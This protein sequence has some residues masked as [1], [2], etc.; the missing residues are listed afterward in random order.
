MGRFLSQKEMSNARYTQEVFNSMLKRGE[1]YNA[2]NIVQERMIVCGCGVEGCM[3]VSLVR[4]ETEEQ[5]KQRFD[6]YERN[7]VK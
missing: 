4:N 7:G 5:R 3:F 1:V 2:D 6:H